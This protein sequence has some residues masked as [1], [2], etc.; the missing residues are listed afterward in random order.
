MST[1]VMKQPRRQFL[2]FVFVGG[3]AAGVNFLSRIGFNI[4]LSYTTSIVLAY[5]V[6]MV[7]AFLL[8]RALVFRDTTNAIHHQIFWFVVINMAAVAQ[9]LL[10][11]L[12]LADYI[13]P[14]CGFHWH[15]KE[16]SHAA[17]IVAPVL[18]SFVGHKK[19]TFRT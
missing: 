19:L 11:S 3:T 6:G 8:N 13:F 18:T 4:W 16:V 14:S 15:V 17:G 7:T 2:L 1:I 12:A 10:V 5:L 9:T